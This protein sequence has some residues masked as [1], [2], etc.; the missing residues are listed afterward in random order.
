MKHTH[1]KIIIP[2]LAIALAT[3]C[4]GKSGD[5]R[6]H[7][8]SSSVNM[9]Q[10]AETADSLIHK[11]LSS[12]DP[13]LEWTH[14][15]SDD[16]PCA[17]SPGHG[18]VTRRAAVMTQISEEHRGAL[19]GVI[20]RNWKK[21]GHSITKVNPDKEFPAI[22]AESEDGVLKMSL[23]VGHKGQFFLNVQTACLKTSAVSRPATQGNGNDYYGEK[24][25]SPNVRSNFWSATNAPSASPGEK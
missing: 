5:S 11:T 15:I 8:R 1:L 3:G 23:T 25:P 20:E 2:F 16:G 17:N 18:D 14:D 10:A 4:A 9:Q 12:I 24:I 19:L 22:Y 7:Q 21:S 6:N 13:S